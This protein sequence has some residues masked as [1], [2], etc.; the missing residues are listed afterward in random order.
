MSPFS[1][2]SD[3]LSLAVRI[4]KEGIPDFSPHQIR[5]MNSMQNEFREL[6]QCK[7]RSGADFACVADKLFPDEFRNLSK[8]WK[9][10]KDKE[11]CRDQIFDVCKKL[12]CEW[13]TLVFAGKKF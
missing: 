9:D 4:I 12:H 11:I 5:E 1:A 7:R 10:Y 6:Q 2:D 13:S 8:C 3:C